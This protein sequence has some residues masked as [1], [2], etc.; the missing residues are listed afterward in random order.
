MGA[1]AVIVVAE[2]F[3]DIFCVAARPAKRN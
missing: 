1:Q 2:G 3:S